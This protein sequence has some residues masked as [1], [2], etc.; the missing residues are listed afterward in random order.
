MNLTPADL[1]FWLAS[2]GGA[3]FAI[4]FV[5]GEVAAKVHYGHTHPKGHR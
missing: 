4:G 2:V 5:A 1:L 3:M